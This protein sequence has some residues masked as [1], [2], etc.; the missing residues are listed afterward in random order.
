M[1]RTPMVVVAVP[2]FPYF[3]I[4]GLW[5]T[6]KTGRVESCSTTAFD[7]KLLNATL[8]NQLKQQWPNLLVG[9]D[10]TF[11]KHEWKKHG[12]CSENKFD[13]PNYFQL[14]INIKQ[15][16]DIHGILVAA[17]Y[18]PTQNKQFNDTDLI[19]VI[20]A[21]TG[22]EPELYCQSV[23]INRVRHIFLT[24]IVLCLNPD[25]VDYTSCPPTTNS[26]VAL[27]KSNLFEFPVK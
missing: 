1:G 7:V 17:G 2:S 25:G 8:T 24:E 19:R 23:N 22:F 21:K 15:R 12:T 16:L 18:A 27:C 6:N 5:P 9:Q 11:W 10:D 3:T 26:A 13:L 14:T 4:H 20:K